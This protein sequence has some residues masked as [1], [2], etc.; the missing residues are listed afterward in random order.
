[1]GERRA[2]PRRGSSPGVAG[3]RI[4]HPASL[5]AGGRGVRSLRGPTE[6]S[7]LERVRAFPR[8]GEAQPRRH[9]ES[10]GSESRPRG[11]PHRKPAPHGSRASRSRMADALAGCPS[12]AP[13]SPARGQRARGSAA[14]R[15][16]A[17][18]DRDRRADAA[19]RDPFRRYRGEP[20]A[21]RPSAP[22]RPGCAGRPAGRRRARGSRP[23]G[24]GRCT[25]CRPA[26]AAPGGPRAGAAGAAAAAR[27]RPGSRS[28]A[29]DDAPARR[30]HASAGTGTVPT[31]RSSAS[32]AASPAAS[33][34][35]PASA[36]ASTRS[37]SASASV[38]SAAA[39]TPAASASALGARAAAASTGSVS[40]SSHADAPARA[41]P[42]ARPAEPS[43]RAGVPRVHRPE[44]PT[45]ARVL[46]PGPRRRRARL[47]A[48]SRELLLG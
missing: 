24:V 45:G 36:P 31:A 8:P 33:S 16:L 34:S 38:C 6:R 5:V 13:G 27:A 10:E 42:P 21:R 15:R 4:A 35:A 7:S 2:S 44:R 40:A 41:A 18:R 23:G 3:V 32:P 25:P 20:R 22:A 9:P 17:S 30:S 26:R 19:G 39:G 12:G 28:V 37:A 47:R 48:A 11:I 1:M 29:P 14:R 46:G 43:E